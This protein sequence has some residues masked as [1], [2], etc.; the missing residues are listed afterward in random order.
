MTIIRTREGPYASMVA[1]S[2]QEREV[3][4]EG[5]RS[6]AAR[7]TRR[8]LIALCIIALLSITAFSGTRLIIRHQDEN[9]TVINVASRQRM[10]T[11]EIA[12][13]ALRMAVHEDPATRARARV[14]LGRAI[15][16]MERS[17]RALI[18]GDAEYGL[19]AE[20]R[21]ALRRMYFAPPLELDLLVSDFLLS[22][23]S[24]TAL[25]D[26]SI[27]PDH[28]DLR[29][30]RDAAAGRLLRALDIAVT[31]YEEAA[32]REVEDLRRAE[33]AVLLVTLLVLVLVALL[34]FRPMVARFRLEAHRF[35]ESQD[36]L[37]RVAH[38]DEL[39]GL[40]NRTLFQLRLE[41]ALAQARRDGTLTAVLQLDLDHFKDV[42]DT[43]GH[44]AGDR[45][46]SEIASRL[47]EMLRDTDTVARV[48]GDEFALILTGLKS[49][50]QVV[51]VAEK[52]VEAI[53]RPVD[54]GDHAVHTSASIG[55]TLFPSDDE[56]PEQLL[57]NADIALYQAKA[58]GRNTFTFFISEMKVRVERRAQL[59]SDLRRALSADEFELH[60]QPQVRLADRATVGIEALLRWR[61]PR[62]GLI[63]PSA[64]L[65][66]AEETNLIVPIGFAMLER[67]ARALRSLD[68]AGLPPLRLALNLAGAQ[69][70]SPGFIETFET[71]LGEAGVAP[72]RLEVEITEGI[73]LGRGHEKIA[74]VLDELRRL[75]VSIAVDDFGTGQASLTHLKR[76]KVDRLKIDRS[77]VR[78]IGI[79][80]DDAAIVRAVTNLG[81]SLALE[82]IA[83]GVEHED[84]LTFLKLQGCDLAQG[85]LFSRPIPPEE[86][87][88]HLRASEV[89]APDGRQ[90][91]RLA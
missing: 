81:H 22:A 1:S 6:L 85:Y 14:G 87:V 35:L 49:P 41:M 39:T 38:H 69:L 16:V 43:L 21:S 25:A 44:A 48:G 88:D 75:G 70:R 29:R 19:R 20:S 63:T 79:D 76:V 84:Q 40:P 86:I 66:V 31:R 89:A 8:Y 80:P 56:E 47:T 4:R 27:E 68:E 83:E 26:G 13:L 77:F 82:V 17:H 36:A 72:D 34:I 2:L 74:T 52:I 73:M 55:I 62:H 33:L 65:A 50:H 54:H 45:L 15:N 60:F 42:N 57:K 12:N 58:Q 3:A 37:E 59:E 46:L 90:R 71:A 51:P 9:F 53:G 24:L 61:H 28:A 5:I 32:A 91:Q 23:A 30:V 11:Q 64:F 78:D 7:M 67:A 10:L 18:H